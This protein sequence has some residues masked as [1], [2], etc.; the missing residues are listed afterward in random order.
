MKIVNIKNHKLFAIC[1]F[2]SAS[3]CLSTTRYLFPKARPSVRS[4]AW[5]PGTVAFNL[6]PLVCLINYNIYIQNGQ[7][8]SGA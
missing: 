7:H 4:D 2:I 6:Y 3:G 1:F 8:G 5:A